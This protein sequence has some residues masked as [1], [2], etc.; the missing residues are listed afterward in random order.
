MTSPLKVACFAYHEV[1][2]DPTSSG[3]QRP[4]AL[5]YKHTRLAFAQHL[6]HMA[7]A[8]AIPVAVTGVDLSKPGRKL[9]LTFDDGGKSALYIADE[10]SARGWIGHF[11]IVTERL[12]TRGFLRRSE[13]R[14]IRSLGH[15]IGSHSHTHPDIFREQSLEQMLYEW[16]T[17][18][19]ILAQITGERCDTASVPGG[20]ISTLVLRSAGAAG[21]TH[22]FTCEPVLAP[23]R[24]DGTWILG[25]YLVKTHTPLLRIHELAQFQG[26]ATARVARLMKNAVRRS[27]PGLYRQY[28]SRTT[29]EWHQ[30]LLPVAANSPQRP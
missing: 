22:L 4:G 5:P 24:V 21:F 11:F 15:V 19:D 30:P 9:L 17:S 25:R 7:T 13:V 28:V 10:L 23:S 27:L 6:A 26:W 3:F 14:H 12:G 18:A 2:D 20:H 1:T 29:R 16:Y 8:P